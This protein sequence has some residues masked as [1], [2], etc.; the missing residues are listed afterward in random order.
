MERYSIINSNSQKEW[1]AGCP[2]K[3]EK[4]NILMDN[5]AKQ[6]VVQ[7]KFFALGNKRIKSIWVDIL[8]YDD[9]S[10]YITGVSDVLYTNLETTMKRSFG[11]EQPVPIES[12]KISGIKVII[13]K[14]DFVDGSI[15]NN[16]N[17][18]IGI[19]PPEQADAKIFF[20][21]LYD[22]FFI[23]TKKVRA[24][25][26]KVLNVTDNF[27]QCTCG[28][29]NSVND[30]NCV[31]CG[32]NIFRLAQISDKAYLE[33]EKNIRME[34]ERK[35]REQQAKIQ[36]ENE[37]LAAEKAERERIR[38]AK[39]AEE[40][41][42][43][44]EKRKKIIIRTVGIVAVL[45][46][47]FVCV[48]NIIKFFMY[49]GA[50][51]AMESAKYD[52]AIETFVKLD[53]FKDSTDKI[54]EAK[55][56]KG[57]LFIKNGEWDQ[58]INIFTELGD[59]NDSADKIKKTKY[60]K[61]DDFSKSENLENITEAIHIYI[62]LDGY[63]DSEQKIKET[64]YKLAVVEY[65]SYDF[66]NAASHYKLCGDYSNAAAMSI[67]AENQIKLT[68]A[69]NYYNDGNYKEAINHVIKILGV[70]SANPKVASANEI[71]EWSK[72]KI[73]TQ[74]IS[75]KMD[76]SNMINDLEYLAKYNYK[77]SNQRLENIKNRFKNISGTYYDGFI[78]V[79]QI[80]AD[81]KTN[82]VYHRFVVLDISGNNDI[83]L[84]D[85]SSQ[86]LSTGGTYGS[87]RP[88]ESSD[89]TVNLYSGYL[90]DDGETYIKQS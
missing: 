72:Q 21:K 77:D 48:N 9:K 4:Y 90:T 57:E 15:W 63:N 16:D 36:A 87:F 64:Y 82:M 68:E 71:L 12:K 44:A 25:N 85:D 30:E 70:A 59:Y 80:E 83:I 19:I 14:V 8:C 54:L 6:N 13:K 24:S 67:S 53:S 58:A 78:R 32:A 81:Y 79:W 88:S 73:Y 45:F 28:Q 76:Y 40:R 39:L 47:S 7:I 49:N 1:L 34:K 55:Y 62:E 51:K 65:N 31:A 23:E 20:G 74:V 86:L 46:I 5:L 42:I 61:A 52:K 41:R 69:A 2:V 89:E 10:E 29:T 60:L 84:M 66:A 38:A 22:Q 37:R 43:A 33:E 75:G 56:L 11:D 27:W 3:V 18:D 50:I 17:S 26:I 35:E